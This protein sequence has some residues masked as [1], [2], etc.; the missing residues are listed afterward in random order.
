MFD[1]KIIKTAFGAGISIYL[2]DLFKINFGVTAGIITIIT[3]Q[4]TKKESITIALERFMASAVGLFISAVLFTFVGINPIVFGIFVMFFMHLCLYLNLFQGF[5]PTVVL[6]TH[7]LVIRDVS[8]QSILNEIYILILGTIVALALNM[9]MPDEEENLSKMR[10]TIDNEIKRVLNYFADIILTGAVSVNEKLIFKKLK[11]D[12]ALYREAALRKFNNELLDE[13]KHD[14]DHVNMERSRYKVLNR[15]RSYFY[16]FYI[17]GDYAQHVADF[18]RRVANTI[19]NEDMCDDIL[20]EFYELKEEFKA[21]SLPETRE[22]FES[23]AIFFQFLNGM[24]EF[25]EIKREFLKNLK[26]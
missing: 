10:D 22:E 14:L 6:V 23:R 2:A 12:I 11:N 17:G 3:I 24:E 16:G 9:Y 4:S 26:K 19:G 15:M 13:C 20:V 5:L 21:L 25:L 8:Y 7:M 18:T 1:H